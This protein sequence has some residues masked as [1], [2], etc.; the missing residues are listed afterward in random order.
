MMA[1]VCNELYLGATL[2]GCT[3]GDVPHSRRPGETLV[4]DHHPE[5]E[6]NKGNPRR[7]GYWRGGPRV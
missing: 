1:V 4:Q 6:E 2:T 5:E 7:E 3:I